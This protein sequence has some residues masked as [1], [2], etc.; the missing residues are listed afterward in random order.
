M[1]RL[2]AVLLLVIAGCASGPTPRELLEL[3]YRGIRRQVLVFVPYPN[4]EIACV[5]W[6]R[7]KDA[8]SPR[9]V[10]ERCHAELLKRAKAAKP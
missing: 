1:R 2:L 6:M 4:G 10:A 7:E 8:V 9:K 3:G 5:V